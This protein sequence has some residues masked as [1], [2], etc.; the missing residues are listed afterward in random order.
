MFGTPAASIKRCTNC[1][2]AVLR[3]DTLI[4]WIGM[5]S[6]VMLSWR[7]V[8]DGGEIDVKGLLMVLLRKREAVAHGFGVAV[9]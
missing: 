8:A 6:S 1:A 4:C 5:E 2:S 9:A 3:S 7:G